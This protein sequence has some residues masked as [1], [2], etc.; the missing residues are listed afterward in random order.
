[1]KNKPI[2]KP[3]IEM[4]DGHTESWS[5]AMAIVMVIWAISMVAIPLIMG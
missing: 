1:M 3:H 5:K 4:D 2:A